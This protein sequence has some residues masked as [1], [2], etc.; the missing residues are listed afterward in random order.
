MKRILTLI[1]IPLLSIFN[2]NAQGGC[3]AYF[4]YTSPNCPTVNFYDGSFADSTQQNFIAGWSWSFGDGATSTQQN[5]SHTYASN[6]MYLVCLTIQSTNGC[7]DTYCDTIDISCI[8]QT[9]C[10]DPTIIDSTIICT[11][12]I[13]PVC[14]C[15]GVTYNNSCEAE[16]YYGVT[17]WTQGPCSQQSSCT[18]DFMITPNSQCPTYVFSDMSSSTQPIVEWYYDFGD[19]NTSTSANTT[20]TYSSN[21]VYTVCLYT[22]SADSCTSSYCTQITV[23]CLGQQSGCQAGFIMDSTSQC[24]TIQL[25][26][27]SSSQFQVVEWYYDFGDGS[28]SNDPNPSHT[29][30]QN[31]T[32][33][34]CLEVVASDSCYNTYCETIVVDCV[35][36][37]EQLELVEM[38]LYPNPAKDHFELQLTDARAIEYTIFG[39]NGQVYQQGAR[40]NNNKHRFDISQMAQG[41]YLL[42]VIVDDR[43]EMIRFMKD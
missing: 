40:S 42:E 31:G 32:Y 41:M 1:A 33:T 35:A 6:G 14:G 28:T 7:S 29:Y 3:Q 4:Q 11:T 19:G 36:G 21:G 9:G 15:D 23:D 43:C 38:T 5:P 34:V 13:D 2:S 39:L 18:A 22:T 20:H 12:V 24:P 27:N 10:I 8:G 37:I 17:S 30:L 16:N 25:Y 26:D